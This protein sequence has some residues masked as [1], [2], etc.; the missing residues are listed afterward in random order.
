MAK[1]ERPSVAFFVMA[2]EVP[3]MS[4]PV[5]DILGPDGDLA[6]FA[7]ARFLEPSLR[8]RVR[9]VVRTS[10][11]WLCSC[12]GQMLCDTCGGLVNKLLG[13]AHA[14]LR[15]CARGELPTTKAG[16][17]LRE[18][19][20]IAGGMTEPAPTA[21]LDADEA[22]REL[23]AYTTRHA[24]PA[25]PAA[26]K[27]PAG[28]AARSPA[29]YTDETWLRACWAQLVLH[30]TR[31][32]DVDLIREDA[33]RRGLPAKPMEALKGSP[34]RGPL[35]ADPQ[36]DA[37]VRELIVGLHA[38][39]ADPFQLPATEKAFGLAAAPARAALDR[40]RALLRA[41]DPS[42][43]E[44][45]VAGPVAGRGL[46]QLP[47]RPAR[48]RPGAEPDGVPGAGACLASFVGPSGLG[49]P[50]GLASF[51]GLA[52]GQ[53]GADGGA[54]PTTEQARR[55][56]RA[57]ITAALDGAARSGRRR[58]G[59]PGPVRLL[60]AIVDAVTGQDV[61]LVARCRRL[62]RLDEAAAGAE[63][64]RL[65]M[66]V[67]AAGVSWLDDALARLDEAA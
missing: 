59:Q 55:A 45:L 36:A 18:F 32:L 50:S 14:K 52:T 30:P 35:A 58:A 53:P 4:L 34:A 57:E 66:L 62:L 42:L 49:G 22:G 9:R 21:L 63:L 46:G 51:A 27:N 61:D 8:V 1:D 16:V 39:V 60:A 25:G 31:K 7:L 12:D 56:L 43:Y 44:T 26:A 17:P 33:V 23:V 19:A 13:A 64:A 67:A 65:G 37:A 5:F 6:A 28:P 2:S 54:A 47:A 15:A 10:V 29:V 24:R 3:R 40:G 20:V 41:H 11:P 38:N 48:P